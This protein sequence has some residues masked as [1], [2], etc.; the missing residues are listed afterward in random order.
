MKVSVSFQSPVPAPISKG[1]R[2]ATL[3]VTVPGE[4]PVEVPLVAGNDVPRLGLIGRLATAVK[5]I[6]WGDSR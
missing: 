3:V 6:I 5:S 4:D 1:D 2:V